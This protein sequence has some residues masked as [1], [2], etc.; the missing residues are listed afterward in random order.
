MLFRSR[1][2]DGDKEFVFI[3]EG[4]CK[5]LICRAEDIRYV[6]PGAVYPVRHCKECGRELPETAWEGH[7][8]TATTEGG[9]THTATVT[10]NS[11][12]TAKG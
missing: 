9:E 6:N 8:I 5:I 11:R 4:S 7:R 12:H 3:G 1:E 10:S 2:A